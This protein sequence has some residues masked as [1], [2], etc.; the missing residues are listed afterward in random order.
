MNADTSKIILTSK[1]EKELLAACRSRLPYEACGIVLAAQSDTE[2]NEALM[3]PDSFAIVRNV[4]TNPERT[5]RFSPEEYVAA[6]YEAQK[7]QRRLV[8]FFHS[9][10]TGEPLPSF[11][12]GQ[13]SLS[14]G[15][16]WIVGLGK[17]SG[18]EIAV[19]R[20]D[21]AGDWLPLSLERVP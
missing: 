13:G 17:E 16:Y 6:V 11:E 15:T 2:G 9:H 5:F 19:Y 10:P 8:G 14:W 20:R 12:D 1:L 4:S 3:K 18:P 21:E 7:N